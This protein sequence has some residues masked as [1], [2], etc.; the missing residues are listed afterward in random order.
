MGFG[1]VYK[2]QVLVELYSI[3]TLTDGIQLSKYQAGL[4][5]EMQ[6]AMSHARLRWFGGQRLRAL[7]EKL[8]K[9]ESVKTVPPAE[10]FKA[11]LRPYQQ[12]GLSWL[13]LI[14]Q[15]GLV[16]RELNSIGQRLYAI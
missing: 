3:K 15:S 16:F 5:Y 1:D 9:F 6:Q 4:L 13:H 10:N 14:Q 11:T 7:G 2:R 8:S 12:T